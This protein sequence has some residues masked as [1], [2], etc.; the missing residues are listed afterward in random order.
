MSYYGTYAFL[1]LVF[2]LVKCISAFPFREFE[3]VQ[4]KKLVS[5]KIT[6]TVVFLTTHNYFSFFSEAFE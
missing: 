5:L 6:V 4:T 1:L 3:S 2:A